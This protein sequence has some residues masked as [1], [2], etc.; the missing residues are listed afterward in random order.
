MEPV[1][2]LLSTAQNEI[3]YLEKRTNAQL[4][5]K[6]A[7]AGSANFTKYWR[8]LF[9]EW[10]GQPWCDCFVSW[11]FYKTFG[12]KDAQ[13]LLYGGLYSYYTPASANFFKANKQ[14]FKS[15]K[16][17]DQVFFNVGGNIG[18]T[19]IVEDVRNGYVITI[20][21]N[22]SGASGVIQNGGGVCRKSYKVGSSYI[23]GYGRPNYKI[24]E[25]EDE[26]MSYPQ[27]LEY[28]EQYN[29][30]VAVKGA[31]EGFE[32]QIQ[33]WARENG[34]SDGNQPQAPVKRWQVWAMM[35]KLYEM[36][37]NKLGDDGK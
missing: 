13:A 30:E 27:F 21:G 23:A 14:Y 11:C 8:D 20:E 28:M 34:L 2:R 32:Q 29:K 31:S 25:K 37:M 6:T 12:A 16:A 1:E 19:G 9:P 15:P 36:I 4:E 24:I 5:S 35:K 7:N 33:Q 10:Q 3:G 18:H 17:G 26:D 22:T